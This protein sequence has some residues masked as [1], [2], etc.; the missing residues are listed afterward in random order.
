MLLELDKT[1]EGFIQLFL[2]PENH[3]PAEWFKRSLMAMMQMQMKK[4]SL[5]FTRRF[6]DVY[7]DP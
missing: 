6:C 3:S 4:L 7:T 1:C 5:F 2:N